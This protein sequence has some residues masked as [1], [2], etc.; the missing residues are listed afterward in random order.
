MSLFL[1]WEGKWHDLWIITSSEK[2]TRW[3]NWPQ[4]VKGMGEAP[5]NPCMPWITNLIS[6]CTSPHNSDVS[7]KSL[8]THER[9]WGRETVFSRHIFA[10]GAGTKA[11]KDVDEEIVW[12]RLLTDYRALSWKVYFF[13]TKCGRGNWKIEITI[14]S[15]LVQ[16]S[17]GQ[18]SA[19]SSNNQDSQKTN[20]KSPNYPSI[21]EVCAYSPIYGFG[22]VCKKQVG[23][24]EVL[25]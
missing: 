19:Q 23:S 7:V 24:Q 22:S 21:I 2:E 17:N 11:D 6:L 1:G 25:S 3:N 14:A 13:L 8:I 9:P 15:N 20:R 10:F 18:V 4:I 16:I 12:T 5:R